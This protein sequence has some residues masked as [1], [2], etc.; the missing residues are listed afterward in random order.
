M[1]TSYILRQID[2]AL[3][4]QVKAKAAL[5]NVTIK[6]VIERLL[7]AWLDSS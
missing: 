3:W 2:P 4:R 7:T 1:S 6:T 5:E